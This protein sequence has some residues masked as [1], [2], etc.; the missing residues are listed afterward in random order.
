MGLFS[1]LTNA[2]GDVVNIGLSAIPGVGQYLGTQ[3][4]NAA[5]A[6]QAANQMQFQERMSNTAH[7]R[8]V[9]DLKNAGLNP[10]LAAGG[11]GASTPGGAAA[12]MQ[13]AYSGL[14]ETA[15]SVLGMMNSKKDL[16][17]KDENIDLTKEQNK[18]Q[19]FQQ[20][21]L[22]QQERKTRSD[23]AISEATAKDEFYKQA[24]KE[25]PN[26]VDQTGFIVPSFYREQAKTNQAIMKANASSAR[27]TLLDEKFHQDHNT[28]DNVTDRSGKV[29]GQAANAA[30][31]ITPGIKL[32]THFDN[33]A[34]SYKVHKQTGEILP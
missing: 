5:N 28:F 18:T 19:K 15:S 31:M 26:M 33:S 29:I 32:Q 23:A 6:Q 8:E 14:G 2:L 12:T 4:A 3:S 34:N 17:Q 22:K 21:L 27:S 10:I 13:N 16:E 25:N 7:T 30:S 1:G 24:A 9:A 11:G 20:D